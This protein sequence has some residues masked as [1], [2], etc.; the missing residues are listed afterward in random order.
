MELFV[1]VAGFISILAVLVY[2]RSRK[3][4]IEIKTPDIIVA[5]LPVF[6]FL[7]ISGKLSKFELSESGLKIETA[8]N[9]AA[10][11]QISGLEMSV[12]L[13][14][15]PARS[16]STDPKSMVEDIPELINKKTE[17]L[18][19]KLGFDGYNGKAIYWFLSELTEKPYLKHLIFLDNE[20]KFFGISPASSFIK[21]YPDSGR[22]YEQLASW[23]INNNEEKIK[24]FVPGIITH[25]EALMSTTSRN[26][27][28]SKMVELKVN[29]LPVLDGKGNFVGMVER[30]AISSSLLLEIAS[31]MNE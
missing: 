6:I 21:L 24:A 7:L 12:D 17:A 14:K 30:N 26:A 5:I 3:K 22:S 29:E 8:I 31:K 10:K 19:F 4:A 9:E 23:L 25:E 18:S 16:L 20:G 27:A 11:S 15:L 13:E 28:L 2:M 1:S